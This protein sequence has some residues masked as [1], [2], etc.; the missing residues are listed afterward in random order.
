MMKTLLFT[1][2]SLRMM[3]LLITVMLVT[4]CMTTQFAHTVETALDRCPALKSYNA[5]DGVIKCYD[6]KSDNVLTIEAK[7]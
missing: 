1:L 7:E 3:S 4:S 5:K 6:Y 2:I